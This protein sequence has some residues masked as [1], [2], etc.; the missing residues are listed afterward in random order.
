[1]TIDFENRILFQRSSS[2]EIMRFVI[3]ITHYFVK[4]PDI[5]SI[6]TSLRRKILFNAESIVMYF[7][8]C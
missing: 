6:E 5:I 8:I 4:V 3:S 7:L 1:M 2:Q